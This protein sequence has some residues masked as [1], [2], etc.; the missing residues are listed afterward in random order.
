MKALILYVAFV[1]IGGLLCVAIGYLVEPKVSMTAS[2]IVFLTLFLAN[3]VASW[4]AV[5]LVIDRSLK[6]CARSTAQLDIEEA[7][8]EPAGGMPWAP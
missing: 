7:G 1:T 6:R 5:G 4:I 2:L 3:F 8:R